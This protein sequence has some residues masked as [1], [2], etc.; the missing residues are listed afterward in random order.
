MMR[1]AAD[2]QLGAQLPGGQQL[3][4]VPEAL[5]SGQSILYRVR[6]RL[7]GLLGLGASLEEHSV[8]RSQAQAGYL[9]QGLWSGLEDHAY[10]ANGAG[11]LIEDQAAVEL[12][13]RN[14][15]SNNLL[16]GLQ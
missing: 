9:H 10:D 15:L 14:E 12:G 2:A 7:V 8:T 13:A 1:G 5:I 6:Q 16:L 3:H 4:R 11:Y